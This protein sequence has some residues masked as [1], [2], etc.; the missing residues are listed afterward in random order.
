MFTKL[1]PSA[2]SSAGCSSKLRRRFFRFSN[3]QTQA[4]RLVVLVIAIGFPIALVIAWAFELTPDGL[5]A[6]KL[7][8]PSA[9]TRAVRP[10]SMPSRSAQPFH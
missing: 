9:N 10:E 7:P 2:P 6:P 8:M 1:P 3:F 4:V 5:S